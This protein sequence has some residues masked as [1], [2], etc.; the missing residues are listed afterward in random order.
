MARSAFLET[1]IVCPVCKAPVTL[2]Y[3]NPKLYAVAQRDADRRVTAYTW[4]QGVDTDAIPHYYAVLQCPQC[5]FADFREDL[6]NA[7]SSVKSRLVYQARN[8]LDMK[9]VLM[10]KKLRRVV[11][12]GT[13]TLDGAIALH[14]AAIYQALLPA[15]DAN[16]D[17]NKLGR[18]YL[19]L[20]WLYREQNG[21]SEPLPD[22]KEEVAESEVIKS[23]MEA[24]ESLQQ[25]MSELTEDISGV[26][27]LV[28]QRAVELG[29]PEEG[30]QNPY[31]YMVSAMDAKKNELQTLVEM[32]QQSVTTDKRGQ[33]VAAPQETVE[34]NSQSQELFNSIATQWPD[35]PRNE[36]SCIQRAVAAFDYSYNHED[37]ELSA[38]Q[39]L[40]VVNLIVKLLLKI[41]DLDGALNY[42]MQ[43]FKTGFRD[44]QELQRRLS[45]GKQ[46]KKISPLDE[47]N[48][49]RKI[50]MINNT[51]SQA[52]ETRHQIVE[53]IYE[54]RK[55]KI[56]AI[57]K[58]NADKSSEQINQALL[59]AGFSEVV[60]HFL[61][62]KGLIK[63]EESKKGWFGK[64]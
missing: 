17:Y 11:G 56:H 37:G 52:G 50:G 27:R 14:L 5:C 18:L 20:S 16:I 35:M 61:T 10:L 44:K 47:K 23:L 54:K 41:G 45:Q 4:S 55:D 33:L 43:I 25:D 40:S 13:I 1:N 58:A 42:V 63:K 6:E 19:R 59:N 53:L 46:D 15:G 30:E 34:S 29:M 12:E 28:R 64:K 3:P 32:F 57:L 8:A 22:L 39:S 21:E 60:I 7:G 49:Q 51:L 9:R 24:V 2:R 36:V 62:E 26:R 48:I 31:W 38:E